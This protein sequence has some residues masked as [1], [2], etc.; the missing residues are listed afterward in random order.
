MA[1]I[2]LEDRVLVSTESFETIERLHKTELKDEEIEIVVKSGMM[3]WKYKAKVN[4]IGLDVK[5]K[6]IKEQGPVTD[7]VRFFDSS[8]KG[9]TSDF[10]EHY[11]FNRVVN[12]TNDAF[13]NLADSNKYEYYDDGTIKPLLKSASFRALSEAEKI[14]GMAS[15][16]VLIE[17]EE[18][19]LK[20]KIGTVDYEK[21]SVKID[22]IKIKVPTER[23]DD[24]VERVEHAQLIER[25]LEQIE[26]LDCHMDPS[27]LR[28]LES[29]IKKE[30]EDELVQSK[31][32]EEQ[33]LKALC[34]RC[35]QIERNLKELDSMIKMLES[36]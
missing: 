5:V 14:D 15:S 26:I 3:K 6:V 23:R 9:C 24:Q 34:E 16:Y 13:V 36:L 20:L 8:P 27:D 18:Q 21:F 35:N 2:L 25:E 29:K 17:P 1:Y 10:L 11:V 33:D 32:K 19:I 4:R 28:Q 30:I 22:E 12:N 7:L 31:Y